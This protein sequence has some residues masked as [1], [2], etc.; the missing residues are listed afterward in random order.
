[1]WPKPN[2]CL[3]P[4]PVPPSLRHRSECY[5]LALLFTWR[6]S[7]RPSRL[8]QMLPADHLTSIL[9]CF[10]T[11]KTLTVFSVATCPAKRQR[12]PASFV[13]GIKKESCWVGLPRTAPQGTDWA[14]RQALWLPVPP[15]SFP[16]GT[17]AGILDQAATLRMGTPF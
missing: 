3:S 7:S 11:N 6:P 4:K 1:M 8:L 9:S 13:I 16:T 14:G 15:S 5:H 2:S 10:L 12:I 17:P